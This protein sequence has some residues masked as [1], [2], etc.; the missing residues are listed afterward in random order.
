LWGQVQ[1][2]QASQHMAPTCRSLAPH[3]HTMQGQLTNRIG[4]FRHRSA[5]LFKYANRNREFISYL[6]SPRLQNLK[7]G[8]EALTK[9]RERAL[10]FQLLAR[11]DV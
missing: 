10:A 5:A 11:R 7:R 1:L 8:R 9:L 4:A 6:T 2:A 3:N